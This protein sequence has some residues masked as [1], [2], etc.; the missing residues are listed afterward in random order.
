MDDLPILSSTTDVQ[1]EREVARQVY[2]R[3]RQKLVVLRA[4][5]EPNAA[6]IDIVVGELEQAEL[7][8]KA[9]HGM[10]GNNPIGDPPFD[11]V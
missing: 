6:A 4:A 3:L 7:A 5:P 9:A 1:L 11:A 8:F 2:D 10:M